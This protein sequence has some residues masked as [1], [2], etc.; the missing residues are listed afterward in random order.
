VLCREDV[1]S[2]RGNAPPRRQR[3]LSQR[4]VRQPNVFS[5]L[6]LTMAVGKDFAVLDDFH[7]C[8]ND[9]ARSRDTAF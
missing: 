5:Y 1:L 8:P 3:D 2:R 9:V 4:L 7:S 6:H